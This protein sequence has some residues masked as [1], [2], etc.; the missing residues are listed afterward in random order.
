MPILQAIKQFHRDLQ[1]RAARHY[2]TQEI[3]RVMQ[4]MH[5]LELAHTP[6]EQWGLVKQ[7]QAAEIQAVRDGKFDIVD[8]RTWQ[9]PYLPEA[10]HRLNQ[11]ILKNCFS[12]DTEIL[13]KRGWVLIS[14]CKKGDSVLS[15]LDDGSAIWVPVLKM[16]KYKHKGTM[17]SFKGKYVDL[18]VSPDHRMYGRFRAPNR[19][20][21]GK[22]RICDVCGKE[23]ST[24]QALGSHRRKI[25]GIA[26]A[27]GY[28]EPKGHLGHYS[29]GKVGFAFAKDVASWLE[30]HAGSIHS[31]E[32][33]VSTKWTG[34]FPSNFDKHTGKIHLE[35]TH[36]SY[37]GYAAR[38]KSYDVDLKDWL[39]FLG[40]WMAE[41]TVKGSCSG[42]DLGPNSKEPHYV[43]A[44]AAA[45][46]TYGPPSCY[47]VSISQMEYGQH[48]AALERLISRLPWKFKKETSPRGQVGFSAYDM[49]LHSQ[50]RRFGNSY[51]KYVPRWIKELPPEYLRIFL[52]W[53][54]K[55]DGHQSFTQSG[56][57]GRSY[58]TVS[59][60]LADDMQEIFLKCG[61]EALVKTVP[62]PTFSKGFG[63]KGRRAP[64]YHVREHG[65]EF[66]GISH[67][68]IGEVRYDGYIYCPAIPPYE[69]VYVRRRQ[70]IACWCGRTPYNLPPVL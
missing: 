51:T 32:I 20:Y 45:A 48:Y 56:K 10:L 70:G 37:W 61:T 49:T 69:T 3:I 21:W 35:C 30:E 2:R 36:P 43:Q 46:E 1:A 11:P 42:M 19:G 41:G 5:E 50:V 59:K 31:F 39:R 68:N 47:A 58:Y 14:Q 29:Y 13:T 55:G 16:M 54:M 60:R 62:P 9:Y 23:L 33:P 24:A 44:I 27:S 26:A 65:F 12:S 22:E 6:G 67:R 18:L 25:H 52:A 4:P 38:R 17:I 53:A 28:N 63:R 8:R 34:E 7:K 40:F 15:R 64:Q 57:G 66:K